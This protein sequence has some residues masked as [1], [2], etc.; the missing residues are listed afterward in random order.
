M[1]AA[2][3]PR[4]LPEVVLIRRAAWTGEGGVHYTQERFLVS[5]GD[6]EDD[7]LKSLRPPRAPW[8]EVTIWNEEHAIGGY[9]GEVWPS[10]WPQFFEVTGRGPNRRMLLTSVA[11]A[12]FDAARQNGAQS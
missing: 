10:A 12:A 4:A 9:G 11:V 2:D 6:I 3:K 5:G 1:T 8:C 7:W